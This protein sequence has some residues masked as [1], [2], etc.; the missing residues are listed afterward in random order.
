MRA[1][2]SADDTPI[3]PFEGSSR[4][5]YFCKHVIAMHM[6]KNFYRGVHAAQP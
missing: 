3:T 6:G 2:E 4:R 5:A 1:I